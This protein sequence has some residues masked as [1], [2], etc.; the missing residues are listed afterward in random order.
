MLYQEHLKVIFSAD[1]KCKCLIIITVFLFDTI[2]CV[3]L[4]RRAQRRQKDAHA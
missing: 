1:Y 4:V 2:V 3:L